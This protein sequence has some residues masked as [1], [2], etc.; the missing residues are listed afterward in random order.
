MIDPP[1][2]FVKDYKEYKTGYLMHMTLRDFL[3]YEGI[4]KSTYY[5]YERKI[6][7]KER[8]ENDYCNEKK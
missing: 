7:E 4:S 5:N 6:L 3:K 1:E 8:R 2:K